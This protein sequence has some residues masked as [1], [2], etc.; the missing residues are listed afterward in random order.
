M[1]NN[2]IGGSANTYSRDLLVCIHDLKRVKALYNDGYLT[3]A[4]T[5]F[6]S[7]ITHLTTLKGI[8]NSATKQTDLNVGPTLAAFPYDTVS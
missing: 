2:P 6:A 1:P 7:T 5:L 8:L 3:D 4:N